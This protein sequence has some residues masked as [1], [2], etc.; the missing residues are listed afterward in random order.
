MSGLPAPLVPAGT[1]MRHL[2]MVPFNGQ[3]FFGSQTYADWIRHPQ[4]GLAGMRLWE[5]AW[6]EVPAGSLPS[7]D[8]RLCLL[9]GLGR[10]MRAWSR[11]KALALSGF[12]L[13]SDGRLYHPDIAEAV[14]DRAGWRYLRPAVER[15]LDVS[16]AEWGALRQEVFC[17]DAY[18]CR[19]CGTEEASLDCDHVVPLSRGGLSVP[20]NLVAACVPCNRSKGALT[21]A[22]WEAR[23]G[24][25]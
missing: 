19:Y 17:R 10:D 22:E 8:R 9:A 4:A 16:P 7:D 24:I 23:R 1:D 14:A 3:R 18:T 11:H 5:A 25:L 21:P 12:I 2:D 20:D 15:R 6:A 13:C